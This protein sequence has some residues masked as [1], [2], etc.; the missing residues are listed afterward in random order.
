[1]G[2]EGRGGVGSVKSNVGFARK[3]RHLVITCSTFH[4][5]FP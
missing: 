3:I 5:G 1:M 4:H 2:G